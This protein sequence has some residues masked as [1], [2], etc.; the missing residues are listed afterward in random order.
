MGFGVGLISDRGIQLGVVH[1]WSGNTFGCGP[2][3]GGTW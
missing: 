1:L 3:L 2:S